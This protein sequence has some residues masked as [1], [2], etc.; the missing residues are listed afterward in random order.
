MIELDG[1][2]ANGWKTPTVPVRRPGVAGGRG[3]VARY[4]I[5]RETDAFAAMGQRHRPILR[6]TC[7][8]LPRYLHGAEDA[9]QPVFLVLAERPEVVRR[10]LVGCLHGLARAAVSELRRT[11]RRRIEREAVAAGIRSLFDRLG[12]GSQ[13]VE[14]HELR[15]EL[16]AALAQLPDQLHQAVILRYLEGL[17]QQEAARRAGCTTTTMGW[18]SMKGLQRAARRPEPPGGRRH[19]RRLAGRAGRRSRVGCGPGVRRCRHRSRLGGRGPRGRGPGEAIAAGQHGAQAGP[20]PAA[21]F[22]S[23]PRGGDGW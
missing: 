1:W 20:C 7:L 9:T 6:R 22:G 13:P 21:G 4:R 5:A 19:Y 14:H 17:S 16:D 15:E 23:R 18:R 11:R 12:R 2:G 8:R 3:V 10:S